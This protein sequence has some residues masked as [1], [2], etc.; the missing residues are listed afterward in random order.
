VATRKIAVFS[1]D[2]D[3]FDVK[4]A[5]PEGVINSV[6]SKLRRSLASAIH[7]AYC[8]CSQRQLPLS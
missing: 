2:L 4:K 6:M 7:A 1:H 8:T 5:S 3:S